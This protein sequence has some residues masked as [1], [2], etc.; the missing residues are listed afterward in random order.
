MMKRI[1]ECAWRTFAAGSVA[2]LLAVG[3]LAPQAQAVDEE[4][5][6]TS[7]TICRA[8]VGAGCYYPGT[9]IFT[10]CNPVVNPSGDCCY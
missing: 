8:M 3:A 10:T 1:Y 4:P 7:F 2:A 9:C 5:G 6:P